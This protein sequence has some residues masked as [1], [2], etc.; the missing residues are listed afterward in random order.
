MR[1]KRKAADEPLNGDHAHNGTR[2]TQRARSVPAHDAFL[3]HVAE[4]SLSRSTGSDS[5]SLG[6]L[7]TQVQMNEPQPAASYHYQRRKSLR[8]V[9]LSGLTTVATTG[10]TTTAVATGAAAPPPPP[11]PSRH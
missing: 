10:A 5:P 4:L 7:L 8:S 6:W 1:Q 2:P 3:T 11:P 9:F